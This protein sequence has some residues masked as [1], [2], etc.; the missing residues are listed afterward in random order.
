[1]GAT[2]GAGGIR[3]SGVGEWGPWSLRLRVGV[4]GVRHGGFYWLLVRVDR[5]LWCRG[6]PM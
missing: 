4:G 2:G 1:M 3:D 6:V 5:M